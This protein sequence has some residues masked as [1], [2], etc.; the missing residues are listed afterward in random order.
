MT[1][2]LSTKFFTIQSNL[3]STNLKNQKKTVK[4]QKIEIL[5]HLSRK[6]T[7]LPKKSGFTVVPNIDQRDSILQ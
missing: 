1:K 3:T 7:E 6:Q 5:N 2:N 4:S